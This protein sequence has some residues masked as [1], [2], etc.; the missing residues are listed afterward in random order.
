MTSIKEPKIK[1]PEMREDQEWDAG[2]V[3][4]DTVSRR[5]AK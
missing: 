1:C 4:E 2:N 3:K 5:G